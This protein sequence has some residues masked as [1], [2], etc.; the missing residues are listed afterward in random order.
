MLLL[1]ILAG[2]SA[3]SDALLCNRVYVLNYLN[4]AIKNLLSFFGIN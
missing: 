4:E 2:Y 3:T 1:L